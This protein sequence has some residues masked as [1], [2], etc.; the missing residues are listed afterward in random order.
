[1]ITS[2]P[3]CKTGF[4]S[5]SADVIDRIITCTCTN[6]MLYL[7]DTS[8]LLLSKSASSLALLLVIL[9][10]PDM[11][12]YRAYLQI[13]FSVKSEILKFKSDF[14]CIWIHS[15]G[16]YWFDFV[17][18]KC[19]TGKWCSS[20][21]VCTVCT[22][23]LYCTHLL[24]CNCIEKPAQSSRQDSLAWRERRRDR[25]EERTDSSHTH[26]HCLVWLL[27]VCYCSLLMGQVQVES[28]LRVEIIKSNKYR[29]E[30]WILNTIFQPGR[31]TVK[32]SNKVRNKKHHFEK[33]DSMSHTRQ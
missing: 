28:S 30:E 26:L 29:V 25:A 18:W 20:L 11:V 22:V 17:Q 3:C 9:T 14:I 33:S 13:W 24:C 27:L 7:L 8:F 16:C 12:Q 2:L 23:E 15:L 31:Y 19:G 6:V 4:K 32:N 21:C 1:M 10:S 5:Y